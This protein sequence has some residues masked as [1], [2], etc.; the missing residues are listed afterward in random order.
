MAW[1]SRRTTAGGDPEAQVHAPQVGRQGRH[2]EASRRETDRLKRLRQLKNRSK[3]R[4]QRRQKTMER[5]FLLAQ[6]SAA[7]QRGSHVASAPHLGPFQ[8]GMNLK[9]DSQRDGLDAA[10]LQKGSIARRGKAQAN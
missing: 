4:R 9:L 6:E 10:N 5:R 8:F 7:K 1:G 2:A 3:K